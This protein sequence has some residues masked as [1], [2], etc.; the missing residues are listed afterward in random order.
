[1]TSSRTTATQ[2]AIDFCIARAA[3]C[4]IENLRDS[5]NPDWKITTPGIDPLTI[6]LDYLATGTCSCYCGTHSPS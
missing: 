6:G 4:A 5:D 1:M 2:S 3:I